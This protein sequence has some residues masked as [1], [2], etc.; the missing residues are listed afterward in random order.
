MPLASPAGRGPCH[1]PGPVTVWVKICGLTS[2]DDALLA[3]DA[4]V[5]AIGLNLVQSSKRCIDL[6]L[7][8]RIHEAVGSQVE[9]VAVVADLS[10]G[11]LASLRQDT[12]IEWLQLHGHEPPEA[13]P[14]LLPHAYKA[15]AVGTA[16]DVTA[17]RRYA[18]ERILTD[19]K[20]SGALGGTGTTFD[21]NLV[22][23]LAGER[24][25]ILAG[26][27]TPENVAQAIERVRPFG[28]DVAS[29]VESGDPRR[30]DESKMRAF[31]RATREERA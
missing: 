20:V 31:V 22:R 26:G 25:L 6:E 10:S 19:A 27:L 12:G 17:A 28:V 9:V 7:A 5:D 29:G 24:G 2:I 3:V 13:L 21:W 8:A 23:E 16:D 4:G 18:G 14:Q 30:K 11:E 15:V 1:A